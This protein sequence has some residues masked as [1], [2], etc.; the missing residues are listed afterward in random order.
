MPIAET[1][2]VPHQRERSARFGARAKNQKGL[3]F[4]DCRDGV[5]IL[6]AV[7]IIRNTVFGGMKGCIPF[8]GKP[9]VARAGGQG[10]NLNTRRLGFRV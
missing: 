10:L 4:R 9:G 6:H 7:L 3:G 1:I 8:L 2:A 5:S